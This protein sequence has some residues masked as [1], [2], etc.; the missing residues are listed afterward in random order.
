MEVTINKSKIVLVQGDIT[1]ETTQAIVN[2][3]NSRLVGR[4][5]S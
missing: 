1:T 3:A 4:R 2:A 5:R